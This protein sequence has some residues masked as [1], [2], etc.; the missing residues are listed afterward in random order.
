MIPLLAEFLS[1]FN[2]LPVFQFHSFFFLILC[3]N[4]FLIFINVAYPSRAWMI[5]IVLI[6]LKL[7]YPFFSLVCHLLTNLLC[8][9]FAVSS[10]FSRLQFHGNVKLS[11]LSFLNVSQKFRQVSGEI[12][13][14]T[15]QAKVWLIKAHL[16]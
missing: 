10:P 2:I 15:F 9:L 14:L 3:L 1:V 11:R 6:F 4:I 16:R 8:R 12:N 5:F 13:N 7:Y